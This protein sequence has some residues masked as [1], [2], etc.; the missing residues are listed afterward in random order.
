[1]CRAILLKYLLCEAK[2]QRRVSIISVSCLLFFAFVMAEMVHAEEKFYSI[3][4]AA[5]RNRES[6]VDLV[7][8]LKRLGYEAFYRHEA[9]R[10]KGTWYRVYIERYSTKREAEKEAKILKKLELIS[11]YAIRAVDKKAKPETRVDER[12]DAVFYVHVGSFN[13]RANAEKLAELLKIN[14]YKAF[15]IEEEI[16]DKTWF[17]VYIGEYSDQKRAEEVGTELREKGFISYYK[18]LMIEKDAFKKKG[19]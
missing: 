14:G 16:S 1:M 4:V 13:N 11:K 19:E 17:R 10:G 7:S 6:A 3:Q 9:V 2:H 8:K 12:G 15:S 5:G 18:T